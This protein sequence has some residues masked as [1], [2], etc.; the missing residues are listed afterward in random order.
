AGVGVDLV[1]DRFE[2]GVGLGVGVIA[3]QEVEGVGGLVGLGGEQVGQA[4]AEPLGQL[5]DHLVAAVDQ[6]AAVL[7]DLAVGPGGGV[8]VHPASHP[9]GGLVDGR[10]VAGVRQGQR[11]VQARDPA[12]DDGDPGL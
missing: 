2:V 3:A 11:R 6:L 4:E 5:L 9:A 7:R 10:G 12:A 1:V 8:R